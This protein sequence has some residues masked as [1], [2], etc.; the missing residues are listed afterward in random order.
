[1]IYLASLMNLAGP[2]MIII[3]L[4]VLILFGARRLPDLAKGMG[5]AMKEFQ[6][7]KD[8]FSHELH[9]AINSDRKRNEATGVIAR[10]NPPTIQSAIASSEAAVA[11][12]ASDGCG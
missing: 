11:T 9:P 2:D 7:A 12:A 10:T 6:K 5:Q 1:M 8:E 3:L 4:I